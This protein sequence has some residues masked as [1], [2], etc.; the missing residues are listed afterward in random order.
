MCHVSEVRI[1]KHDSVTKSRV[2][3]CYPV[4]QKVRGEAGRVSAEKCIQV[5]SS[6]LPTKKHTDPQECSNGGH[7]R[8]A[9][10]QKTIT[11]SGCGQTKNGAFTHD[12]QGSYSVGVR[13]LDEI[14][15]RDCTSIGF[16]GG[17]PDTG[18]DFR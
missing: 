2:H 11:L 1:S 16:G 6:R 18:D 13:L 15:I 5:V 10:F 4:S 14:I 7:K 8:Q 17:G 3:W 9:P 12:C